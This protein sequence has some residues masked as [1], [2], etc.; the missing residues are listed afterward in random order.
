ML[1]FTVRRALPAIPRSTRIQ[2][3]H[4]VPGSSQRF[5]DK[6]RSLTADCV[7]YDLEDSVTPHKKA[8]ARS[9]V[10]RALDEP[11]PAS[12]RE[13]AVRINSVDSG[14]ALAD[15]TEIVR[16]SNYYP[17]ISINQTGE[18]PEPIHNRHPK[19][20]LRIGPHLC[21]RRNH[22]LSRPAAAHRQQTTHLP[23]RPHRVR[24]IP[25][26]PLSD[27]L[28]HSPPAGPHLRRRRLRPRPL[29]N[30]H[31][32]PNRVPVRSLGYRNCR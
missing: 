2:L 5:I 31:S 29:P 23:P 24:Q 8:E 17:C 30:T 12:I 26:K 4:P 19:G 13:R 1:F 6:S 22:P 11:A 20:Q 10:R 15:L 32:G 28:G 27:H 21:Q 9:L 18:I 3:I 14:L 25:H 16:Q 7:A